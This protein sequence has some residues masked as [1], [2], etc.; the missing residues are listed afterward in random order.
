MITGGAGFIGS[1]LV[2]A[3]VSR[4]AEVVILDN[5]SSGKID[6]I[7][8][9]QGNPNVKFIKGDLLNP[10]D[11]EPAVNDC[12]IVFHLA[13]NPDVRTGSSN[14]QSH[15]NQNVMAT[16]NL[17]EVLRKKNNVKV[18]A[19]TSSSTVYGEAPTP[20]P[21]D[22][23]ELKPISVYGATK[24]ACEALISAYAHSYGFR[25]IIYRLANIIGSRSTHGVIV[26][27]IKKLSENPSELEILGDGTQK[28]SYLHVSDCIDAMLLA[29]EKTSNQVDIFNIGSEDQINVMT[30]ARLVVEEMGLKNV[31]F[32]LTGGVHGGRGWIGDVKNMLLD[33]SKLKGL[34]WK[35]RFNSLEAVRRT[36]REIL[37]G[38]AAK[39]RNRPE[40]Y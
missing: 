9:H 5:L 11:I 32:K 33:I 28:K 39:I 14:P 18:L 12:E 16:Y 20:T 8:H 6:N 30:I 37:K 26:D 29:I 17:L 25:A 34:G 3:L 24:L 1:H 7:S 27:F 35:P 19:F 15:F 21:E 4:G 36:I 40:S 22:Y 2:D 38:G 13:A 10:Q 31:K 23:G